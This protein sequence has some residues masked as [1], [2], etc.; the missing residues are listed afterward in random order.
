MHELRKVGRAYKGTANPAQA[1]IRTRDERF[2]AL[3]Q[4][5]KKAVFP[6]RLTRSQAH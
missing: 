3:R 2:V 6:I 5:R 4:A 1:A